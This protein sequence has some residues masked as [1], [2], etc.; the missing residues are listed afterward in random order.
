M[1]LTE[2]D[3]GRRLDARVGEAVQVTLAENPTTGYR[4]HPADATGLEAT[5]DRYD[6]PTEP[7]G[8]A[9]MRRLTF[10]PQRA[11]RLRLRLVLKRSWESAEAGEFVVDLDVEEAAT[12]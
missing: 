10:T 11:G 1:E 5:D 6:G 7:R 9:G 3:S 4:W 12:G 8:A 2:D